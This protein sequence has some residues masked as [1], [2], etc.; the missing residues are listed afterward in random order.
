[1]RLPALRWA[2]VEVEDRS[3]DVDRGAR[4]RNVHHTGE[5]S[6]DWRGTQNHVGLDVR[7]AEFHKVVDRM[8]A[9][10]R[11]GQLRVQVV[12]LA[13]QIYRD[14]REGNPLRVLWIAEAGHKD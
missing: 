10:A 7:V 2:D 3:G 9:G 8:M 6:F 5:P 1:M 14:A 12:L 13:G 4:I 11:V